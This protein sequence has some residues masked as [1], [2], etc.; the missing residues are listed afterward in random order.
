MMI[1]NIKS[2][3]NSV[4]DVSTSIAF[5]DS[6][7]VRTIIRTYYVSYFAFHILYSIKVNDFF[8]IFQYID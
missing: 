2:Q 1:S 8:H 6:G 7:I 5:E 4:D 3:K